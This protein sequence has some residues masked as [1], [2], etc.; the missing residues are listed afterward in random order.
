LSGGC[1]ARVD[2]STLPSASRITRNTGS[3]SLPPRL[4]ATSPLGT[5]SS[6]S[7]AGSLYDYGAPP[8]PR[9]T[10]L[11]SSPNKSRVMS[12]LIQLLVRQ[13]M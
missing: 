13:R 3:G 8:V 1:S 9:M 6:R 10:C 2:S 12:F 7:R 4:T 11:C 5:S